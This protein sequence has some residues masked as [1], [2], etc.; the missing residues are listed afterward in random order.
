M[1]RGY[2]Q[3]HQELLFREEVEQSIIGFAD[4][5]NEIVEFGLVTQAMVNLI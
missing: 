2:K 4:D 1:T 3:W 5:I